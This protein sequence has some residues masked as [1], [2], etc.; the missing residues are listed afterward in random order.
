[1]G[2]PGENLKNF[3]MDSERPTLAEV[4]L[5]EVRYLRAVIEKLE[6]KIE[7]LEEA[8]TNII[9]QQRVFLKAFDSSDLMRKYYRSSLLE[10]DKEE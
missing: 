6:E 5:Y 2:P 7:K 8:T 4:S 10:I 3:D 9:K 1:M